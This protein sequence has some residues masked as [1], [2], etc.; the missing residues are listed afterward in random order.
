MTK[1]KIQNLA[2][3]IEPLHMN[4]LQGRMLRLPAPPSNSNEILFVYGHHASLERVFGFAEALNRYG[5]VTIPDLPGFGGMESFYRIGM[6]PTLDNLAD[7]LAAF[8]KL[9]YKRRRLK[10]LGISFGFVVITRMLQKHPDLVQKVD[11]LISVV[12][13]AHKDDFVF[14]KHNYLLLRYVASVFSNRLPA[15]FA[16][17]LLLRPAIIRA[18]YHRFANRNA[19]LMDA[20]KEEQER[21]IDFEIG[22]WRSNDI[23]TYMDTTISILTLDLCDVRVDMPVYHVAVNPDRYF[24]NTIVEQHL[25]IIFRQCTVVNTTMKGHAQTVVATAKEVAPFFPPKIRSLLAKA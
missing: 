12:G 10:L 8:I 22:L 11:L 14:K 13:F 19:K 4:G 9:R 6:K 16:N 20:S 5:A 7:Y 23:R 18:T 3:Y 25:Q 17:K 2:D 1:Q 24:D 15:W 21:R